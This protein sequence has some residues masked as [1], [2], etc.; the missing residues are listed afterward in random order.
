MSVLHLSGTTNGVKVKKSGEFCCN[1][2][3]GKKKREKKERVS[4]LH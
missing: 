4:F 2:M 3:V 1:V